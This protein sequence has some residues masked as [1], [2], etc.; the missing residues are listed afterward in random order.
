MVHVHRHVTRMNES[1][2]THT[3]EYGKSESELKA[4]FC[5]ILE[6]K[7]S[8]HSGD[9]AA[10]LI[11]LIHI[12]FG[13]FTYDVT[14]SRV[15]WLICMWHDS[16]TYTPFLRTGLLHIQVN[17]QHKWHDSFMF[18]MTHSY[19]TW[20]I[21]TWHDSFTRDMTHS[22]LR[23]S[24]EQDYCTFRWIFSTRDMTNPYVTWLIHVCH[25]LFM[26][27]MTHSY[28]T[29]PSDMTHMPVTL[30]HAHLCYSWHDY[31]TFRRI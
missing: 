25:D 20:P 26:C 8:A 24:W 11:C 17:V 3:Q 30:N 29:R 7:I 22:H 31:C 4:A 23:Y 14:H 2:V 6:S 13:P 16:F 18:D 10:Q 21:Y 1:Q 5:A 15:T 27:V 19:V 28:V 9:C 12:W